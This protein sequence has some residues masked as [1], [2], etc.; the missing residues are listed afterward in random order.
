MN[1][2]KIISMISIIGTDIINYLDFIVYKKQYR[3]LLKISPINPVAI[4]KEQYLAHRKKWSGFGK[5]YS[6]L[7]F[8]LFSRYIGVSEDIL[9]ESI[10]HCFIEP[11]LN[12]IKYRSY[13]EDKNMFDK[14]LCKDFLPQTIIRRIDGVYY[15]ADYNEMSVTD[16]VLSCLCSKYEKIIVKPTIG[17]SSGR[18]VVLF[19]NE[20]PT[21]DFLEKNY[22]GDLVIQES[23]VQHDCLSIFNPTSVNTLRL[24]AYRSPIDNSVKILNG[25]V[26]IGKKGSYLDNAH[27]GGVVVGLLDNG[28]LQD[29][30]IDQY[31]NKYDD[32]NGVDIKVHQYQIPEYDRVIEFVQGVCEQIPHHRLL[33]L[34]IAICK[35]NDNSILPKII[36]YNLSSLGTWVWQYSN[37]PTL[38]SATDEI[39][40]YCL[41]NIKFATKI[42]A[43]RN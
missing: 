25:V 18:G 40:E 5:Y 14:V 11:I 36:E 33:S 37:K 34:D 42:N 7:D 29:F 20:T 27:A 39:I 8:K 35:G 17:S 22:S 24:L 4:T 30:A 26:R 1:F 12:P 6:D 38:G 28:M 3:N 21:L 32:V 31:G 41:R 43:V 10:S 2:N 16:K 23:L 19:S 15:D 9:P 13:Y